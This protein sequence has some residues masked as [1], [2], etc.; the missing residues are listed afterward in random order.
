MASASEGTI[1]LQRLPGPRGL[2]LLG[3]LLQ[4]RPTRIHEI[5][6]NWSRQHGPAFRLK[7]ANRT[8][9]VVSDWQTVTEI[10]RARPDTFRRAASVETVFSDMG[11]TCVLS[12]EGAQWHRQRQ[13][14]MRAY[15]PEH[16]RDYFPTLVAITERLRRR[17]LRA[18]AA[19]EVLDIQADLTRYS[20]DLTAGLAFGSEVNTLDG[21][22]HTLL[23]SLDQIFPAINRRLMSPVA[24]WRYIKLPSDRAL[25]RNMAEL[26]RN[27]D[28]FIAAARARMRSQPE[29]FMRPRNLLEAFLAI[30]DRPDSEFTDDDVYGNVFLTLLVGPDSTAN[31]FSW[32][33]YFLSNDVSAQAALQSE[34]DAL[35]GERTL[36]DAFAEIGNFRYM[37][38]V[39]QETMRLKPSGPILFL[40]A[41]RDVQVGQVCVPSGTPIIA[42]TRLGGLDPEYFPRPEQFAPARWIE[43]SE[44]G[45]GTVVQAAPVKRVGMP[46]GAGARLCPGR[47]LALVQLKMLGSML[48][49]NFHVEQ[50]RGDPVEERFKFSMGPV[51]L[52]VRLRARTPLI[53]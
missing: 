20:L 15:D 24:Y 46:F 44:A 4:I 38:A 43:T 17:W 2:P 36:P 6:E 41:R 39:A 8:A 3:N 28:V 40:E 33:T 49:R 50:I 35:L 29:L 11:M 42:L 12:T 21:R 32:A 7:I 26:R 19:R 14:T 51:N 10:L 13:L 23:Q 1:D 47:Y 5:L 22:D 27:V 25:E 45:Q 37:E 53:R 18:A 31:V 34:A 30:R 48:G 9:L 16:L 52:R